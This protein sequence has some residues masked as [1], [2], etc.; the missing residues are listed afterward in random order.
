MRLFILDP[1]NLAERITIVN[2]SQSSPEREF[3]LKWTDRLLALFRRFSATEKAVFLV[4]VAVALVT[5]LIMAYKANQYFLVT[6]PAE[7]GT[8]T[9]GEIGVPRAV[10]P[11]LAFTDADKDVTALVYA[12][13][14]RRD[15]SGDLVPD[16]AQSYTV[17]PDGLTY[18]FIMKNGLRFDDGTPITADDV[19]YTVNETQDAA[20]KS[21]LRADWSDV[22]VK[23]VSDTEVQFIL[24]QPYAPFL[25]N[26][27][28]GILP[29]HIWEGIS[30]D[31]FAF[32]PYN[33]Q[34]IGD[35]PY[36]VESVDKDG[37]GVPQSYT[38][39][40]SKD[41]AGAH[42]YI[43]TIVL[44]FY[45]D[46]SHAFDAL[47]AGEIESL[48]GID[49]DDAAALASTSAPV[50][51]LSVPVPRLFGVFFN[52]NSN[53][54]FADKAVRQALSMSVD[55]QALVE[56][57]L[58]GYGVPIDSPVPPGVLASSSPVSA[59]DVAGAQAILAKD[60]WVVG[61]DG[62]LAKTVSKKTQELAFSITTADS[63][64]LKEAADMVAADWQA[65][66]A[67]VTVNV[68][69][70][71]D[72]ENA[73]SDRSYDSLLFGQYV[74]TGLDLYAF[75]DS[76]QRNAPGLNVAEYVSASADKQLEAARTATSSAH[77]LADLG[78]FQDI[79]AADVPAVFL[80]SPDL[81]YAL[82]DKVKGADIGSVSVPADRFDGI[83]GWY[84]ATDR[85][86]DIFTKFTL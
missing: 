58:D 42:P 32:S 16:L 24:K 40:P 52:Q 21:P 80:Y 46:E 48:A 72:L 23:K 56:S 29:Q 86:W 6:V 54:V 33:V 63:A 75:W 4:L 28:L 30:D 20:L 68:L 61:L 59:A 15:A 51:I 65:L 18:D 27:T 10:N 39:V 13:L 81:I 76:S 49:P 78:A 8:L 31:Q 70:Y 35:G 3:R 9:E 73:I 11:I 83:A 22:T 12:G 17:S 82:P 55:R 43:G 66:G 2:E 64:D 7:G 57:V 69:E 79:F 53:P 50:N 62:V 77:A 44:R 5:A 85:V 47:E 14:M 67:K 71:G 45:P 1:I 25:A 36:R 41:Y 60:G 84:I 37:N 74:G 38:L 26:T 19:V 34:P